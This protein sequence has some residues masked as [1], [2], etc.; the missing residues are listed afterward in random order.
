MIAFD[1]Y[2]DFTKWSRN[3][4]NYIESDCNSATLYCNLLYK[5]LA[6]HDESITQEVEREL[7]FHNGQKK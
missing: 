1:R 6:Q 4:N 5:A 2:L 3:V 7:N